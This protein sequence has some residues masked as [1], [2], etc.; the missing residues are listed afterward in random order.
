MKQPEITVLMPAYNAA[1]FIGD[2]VRSVL[3]QSFKNFELLIIDDGSTDATAAI[4][5]SFRDE[6]IKLLQQANGGVAAALNR[7][8]IAARAPLIA[9]FDADDLCAPQRLQVQLQ[10][11]QSRPDLL[12]A[13]SAVEY[14]DAE[15]SPVFTWQPPAYEHEEL[16]ALVTESCPFIHSSVIYRR[17]AVIDA[18][19][20]PEG[21]HTFEDHLLWTR[22]LPQGKGINIPEPLVQVRL[23][24]ASVT[25][26]E[27]WRPRS[28][29]RIKAEALRAGRISTDDASRLATIIHAQS[30]GAV[31]EGAYHALL[32]KKYLWNNYDPGKARA[33][34]RRAL[35][36]NPF[37]T[38]G[39]GLLVASFLPPS[40]IRK[41]YQTFKSWRP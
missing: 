11:M 40:W 32:G 36:C 26:D 15:R 5:N 34:L 17:A 21:A 33:S 28:F 8:L 13:G 7:G 35:S 39:Y 2:A 27:R 6:R 14:I 31:K 3:A 19:G 12:I 10:L 22:L 37:Y 41:G 18:G 25:I 16:L 29:R 24:V 30:N 20:Y 9:R 1:A 23:N 4:V 38:A